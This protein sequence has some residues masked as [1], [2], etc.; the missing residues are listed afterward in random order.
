M[1]LD[2]QP[3]P[4]YVYTGIIP[5]ECRA[6]RM[7]QVARGNMSTVSRIKVSGLLVIPPAANRLG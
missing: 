6:G 7:M 4:A 1:E 5:S 2:Q 3:L